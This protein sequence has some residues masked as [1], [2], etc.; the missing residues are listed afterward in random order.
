MK[1][2]T[3]FAAIAAAL[4]LFAFSA[5][6]AEPGIPPD[7][8]IVDT[9]DDPIVDT[10]DDP[11]VDT[12]DDPIVDPGMADTYTKAFSGNYEVEVDGWLWIFEIPDFQYD[13]DNERI[14]SET[15]VTDVGTNAVVAVT[16]L[17][18][19]GDIIACG[20]TPESDVIC[21]QQEADGSTT[22][23]G[24]AVGTSVNLRR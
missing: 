15:N 6:D 4:M 19:A 10:P 11:I 1:W 14:V 24:Q 20:P 22:I 3:F 12:P 9:P 5:C 8:P 23:W 18:E 16:E 2:S 21:L 17:L 13:P 7:D